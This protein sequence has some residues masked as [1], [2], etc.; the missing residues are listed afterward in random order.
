MLAVKPETPWVELG[1]P[2]PSKNVAH[3]CKSVIYVN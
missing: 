2:N 3:F 1:F